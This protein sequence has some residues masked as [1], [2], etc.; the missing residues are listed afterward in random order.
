MF[1]GGINGKA[2]RQSVYTLQ[3]LG[4]IT[5]LFMTLYGMTIVTGFFESRNYAGWTSFAILMAAWNIFG[6]YQLL[7]P[8]RSV[9]QLVR[10]VV[11]YHMF[12]ILFLLFVADFST[13]LF[14][15]FAI[16][17]LASYLC[18]EIKGV[19]WSA[20]IIFVAIIIDFL[21]HPPTL[22][23]VVLVA[24]GYLITVLISVAAIIL[25][26]IRQVDQ[27]EVTHREAVQTN[28]IMTLVNNLADAVISTNQAGV[29][30]IYN[31]A[32]LNLFDTNTPLE[33][34]SIDSVLHLVDENDNESKLVPLFQQA[35]G[36]TINDKLVMPAQGERLRLEIMYAPIRSSFDVPADDQTLDGYVV[37][38]RDV[39]K[40][41]SLE[42]ER[43]EFISVVSHE[44]RTP[45][46]I[47]EG[48]ISNAQFM[49]AKKDADPSKTN[50]TLKTAHDQVVFLSKMVND[51]STLSRAER[52]VADAP[53]I[54]DV[55]ELA[56]DLFNEYHGEAENKGLRFD[57]DLDSKLGT[58]NASRLYLRELLQNFVTN[59]IKYT[60]E[61]GV[62]L[63]IHRAN[64]EIE[65]A[66]RDT[67]IG[68]SKTEQEKVFLKFWRSED[69]RTRETNGT[70]LGLYVARKLARKLGCTIGLKSR[71]NHG[72]TFS[73]SLP[74]ADT[75]DQS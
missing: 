23:Y 31:A 12:A 71:L 8:M 17:A 75:T 30:Q 60:K 68:I 38:I 11:I 45:I 53:E 16:L 22:K 3:V 25:N 43:D 24:I 61:G 48:A 51:L 65:F 66:V 59:S 69:Y 37:I 1:T 28:R 19:I 58:V 49:S 13:P 21:V 15:L 18:L 40:A 34:M 33:G 6:V 39:T 27:E 32:A 74:A 70:G 41:K 4:L 50:D 44:L 55:D 62:T 57:L 64:N 42:E 36:V 47:A 9:Y 20:C 29:I 35:H 56:H 54:I 46:A 63:S 72:S 14:S 7:A 67:G 26:R 52:G 10:N 5:P 73:F 2:E